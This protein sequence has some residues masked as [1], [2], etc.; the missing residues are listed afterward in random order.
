MRPGVIQKSRPIVMPLRQTP[1]LRRS[2]AA[3]WLP[4]ALSDLPQGFG[5]DPERAASL[6]EIVTELELPSQQGRQVAGLD[7]GGVLVRL[8][9]HLAR[10]VAAGWCRHRWG[11]GGSGI[12]H[13]E[14][15]LP[16]HRAGLPPE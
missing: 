1:K 11:A 6:L 13:H 3:V 16:I 10:A 2:S 4:Y 9:Q 8:A 5:I 14:A 15:R 7:D 12:R